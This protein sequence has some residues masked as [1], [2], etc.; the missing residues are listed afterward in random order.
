MSNNLPNVP[1]V[2]DFEQADL[3]GYVQDKSDKFD[4]TRSQQTTGSSGTGPSSDHT[5]GTSLGISQ[6]FSL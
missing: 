4:W 6:M 1:G 5:Y 3:C 2:C